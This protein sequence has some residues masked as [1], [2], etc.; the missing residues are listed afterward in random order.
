MQTGSQDLAALEKTL[1]AITE[2][3]GRLNLDMDVIK[4]RLEGTRIPALTE[5]RDHWRKELDGLEGGSAKKSLISPIS[6]G[7]AFILPSG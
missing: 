7:S 1:D 5:E 6:S 4:K 3:I 2:E